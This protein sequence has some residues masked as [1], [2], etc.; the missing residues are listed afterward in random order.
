MKSGYGALSYFYIAISILIEVGMG[1]VILVDAYQELKVR[2][3]KTIKP[4]ND[5]Q[6][7]FSTKLNLTIAFIA[8]LLATKVLSVAS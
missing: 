4:E 8:S 1:C 3:Q 7:A 6:G 5:K 2:Y